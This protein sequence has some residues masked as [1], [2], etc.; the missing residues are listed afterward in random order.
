[1]PIDKR[2]PRVLN[3]DLDSKLL[4]KAS[5]E[6]ALNLYAGSDNESIEGGSK[7]DAG[8]LVLKNIRGNKQISSEGFPENARLIGSVE[9]A[10]TD[11]TYLFVYS[12]VA[13]NQGIWA[14]DRYGKLPGSAE[15]TIKRIYKSSQFNFP[16]NGFIK[17][18]IV[19]TNAVTSL[20]DSLEGEPYQ[21]EFDKDVIIY[22][23]DGK[24]EPR[25]INAYRAFNSNGNLINGS[26][27]FA[28]ADF[29]TACPKTPLKPITF[30]FDS[31][32]DAAPE[33]NRSVNNFERSPGF[34]FAYQHIY[35]DGMESAIS[36][37]SDIAIPFS[38][39]DQGSRTFVQHPN[40]RCLLT[41]PPAG[42]EVKTIRILG[43]QGNHGSF[44]IIDEIDSSSENQ[45]YPFFNDRVLKGVS[46][47]DVNKQFDSVPR[48]A[49]S[50]AVS[51]NRLMYSNYLD[52]FNK[53]GTTATAEVRYLEKPQDFLDLDI[54][55]TPSSYHEDGSSGNA[56][57]QFDFSQ[58]PNDIPSGTE[59]N[60]S[61]TFSPDRNF[62]LYSPR[63]AGQSVQR[64]PQPLSAFN[65]FFTG[66]N[67]DQS[68]AVDSIANGSSKYVSKPYIWGQSYTGG[69]PPSGV[70]SLPNQW[71]RHHNP[72]INGNPP[73]GFVFASEV[74]E[75]VY[76]TSA[77]SP[78]IFPGGQITFSVNLIANQDIA[79]APFL[80][81]SAVVECFTNPDAEGPL[82]G[83]AN[84][85]SVI[86]S[87]S[88][89]SYQFDLGLSSGGYI[90]Q[91]YIGQ[92]EG[93]GPHQNSEKIVALYGKQA[94]AVSNVPV[95][96]FI[97]NK[98]KPVFKL[99]HTD[100]YSSDSKAHFI[101]KLTRLEDP[102][103]LMCMHETATTE[104]QNAQQPST[105]WM[106][107]SSSHVTQLYSGND[108]GGNGITDW[109]SAYYGPEYASTFL[110]FGNIPD[111]EDGD[112][113]T[114]SAR[115]YGNQVGEL[116][117]AENELLENTEDLV[118]LD[119]EGGPGGGPARELGSQHPYDNLKMNLQGSVTVNPLVA[120]D[121]DLKFLNTAFYSGK[122][123]PSNPGGSSE[124]TCLPFLKRDFASGQASFEY[125]KPEG[126]SDEEGSSL[127]PTSVNFKHNQSVVE[128][129]SKSVTINTPG[130]F[131]VG[132]ESFKTEANHDFGIV[133][134]DERGRH[135]FVDHLSTAFVEGYTDQERPLG[136]KG[137]VEI[138]LHLSGEP[139]SWAHSYKIAYA[140]NS[141]VQDFVQYSA[142]GGF[143]VSDPEDT[144][145][146]A[147][148][149]NIYVSLNYLQNH[150]ISYVSSFGARTPEGGLNF[151]KFEEGDKL[152]VLSHGPGNS[153]TYENYEF[154]VVDT[155]ML[156]DDEN[157][158]GVSPVASN[159]KGQFVVLKDNPD[160]IGFS[161]QDVLEGN[162]SNKWNKNCIFELRTPKKTQ[163][164][165]EQI[166][167]EVSDHYRV[168]KNPLTGALE[169]ELLTVTID[170]GDVW[171]RPVATNV[172]EFISGQYEDIIFDNDGNDSASQPNFTNVFLETVSASDLF[173]SDSYS[174]LS[175]PNVIFE[176]AKETTREATI[177]Y[178]EPSNPE[179]KKVNYSSFNASLANFKDLPEGFGGIQYINDHNDY[180]FVL[181][182]DKVSIILVNKNIISSASGDGT[183]TASSNVLGEAVFYPGR[184]GVSKDP[185]SIF[186]SNEEVYFCNKSLSK[187]Y[188][189]SKQK[190]VEEISSKGM[191]SVIRASIKRAI[192]DDEQIRIVGGYDPLK[193]EYLLTILNPETRFTTGVV[194]VN[195]EPSKPVSVP[196]GEDEDGD[197]DDGGDVAT[198]A[199]LPFTIAYNELFETDLTDDDMS[200]ELAIDYLL[201]LQNDTDTSKHPTHSQLE[202]ISESMS[203]GSKRINAIQAAGAVSLNAQ[204]AL[205]GDRTGEGNLNVGDLLDFLGSVTLNASVYESQPAPELNPLTLNSLD[206]D[207]PVVVDPDPDPPVVVDPDP[208]DPS[209][210]DLFSSPSEAVNFLIDR[211][212]MKVSE[213]NLIGSNLIDNCRFDSDGNGYIGSSDQLDLLAAFNS[214]LAPDE[215]AFVQAGPVG[216]GQISGN[217]TSLECVQYIL[218][219]G[220]LTI[221]QYNSMAQYLKKKVIFD[222]DNDGDVGTADLLSFLTVMGVSNNVQ[223]FF[224]DQ[225]ALNQ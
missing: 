113:A 42:P 152:L 83:D 134:Y 23:T 31:D 126:E 156:G 17:A 137:R 16:Q 121:G 92:G 88:S 158:L 81:K 114:R 148:N 41:V 53:S 194:P 77:S 181:Q 155:V 18:D 72:N 25:K 70:G 35:K 179:S 172:R 207:E 171:F 195:Q 39:I 69:A 51:S 30:A 140:K 1:M 26:N 205:L 124:V 7:S 49:K 132:S 96:Y 14:Y 50:Q 182:E 103:V 85:I 125:Q 212:D 75:V 149:K 192:S 219:D 189:W 40:Y 22:F 191:S 222:Y 204:L 196:G 130:G 60:I 111:Y 208:V 199:N 66:V 206:P 225:L 61:F 211:G 99:K 154:D 12:N 62:H 54:G 131:G 71:K 46:T 176:D 64:G 223:L 27:T 141:S 105:R 160:A 150:P 159:K 210:L 87:Q 67:F 128:L 65:N 165:D 167:Y 123:S 45:E 82:S 129:F 94:T 162:D 63:G 13:S 127:T 198:G 190:G 139:P 209:I 33:D 153:R 10:K 59:I 107:I 170:K 169:H 58:I 218:A 217:A 183:I 55:V 89:G 98:G 193:D 116:L 104:N 57:F 6:D 29:I 119:G 47:N 215:E 147:S 56:A 174:Y 142:G 20:F 197:E 164:V 213:F 221:S 185:S 144:S 3:S 151:Y 203:E 145:F 136:G 97:V 28:E 79:N 175:R 135:G 2:T 109:I 91:N 173:K 143:V 220:T 202:L 101:L 108:W 100:E 5:M 86:S 187:V 178:S 157:P 76:G 8:D 106:L 188:R 44:L 15:N 216:L 200:A 115:G 186:D 166:Y 11:I 161:Y 34:Q 163:E 224:P 21:S 90:S 84:G 112:S 43:R 95:G 184:N 122:I 138:D 110:G 4:D 32:P 146:D 120:S 48:K 93:D 19:R 9:D 52:G 118:L 214:F 36:S 24:N 102:E 80:V 73:S 38:L 201:G 74:Q 133:Y 68:N 168:L 37:Y 177:T 78:F 117:F 180:L